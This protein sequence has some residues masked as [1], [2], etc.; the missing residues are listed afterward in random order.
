MARRSPLPTT[1]LDKVKAFLT[2]TGAR[3]ARPFSRRVL[4]R[5]GVDGTA[6]TIAQMSRQA[7]Q[8]STD[9]LVRLWAIELLD[10]Y[11]L[12]TG[13]HINGRDHEG[14]ARAF[15][16]ELQEGGPGSNLVR[17]QNDPDRTERNESPWIQLG[18]SGKVDC[19]NQATLM[20]ALLMSVGIPAAF[21]TVMTDVRRPDQFSHVYTLA[22]V[23]GRFIPVD[24]SVPF[25]RFGSE[26]RATYGVKTWEIE[27]LPAREW[28]DY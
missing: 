6:D 9:V 1:V 14:I 27:M 15:F 22:R 8:G 4:I 5:D 17:F 7:R 28:S 3:R 19:N 12:R 21:R 25:A 16:E 20:A 13:Q 24:T 11:E 2:K 18:T 23:K 10:R 26:P